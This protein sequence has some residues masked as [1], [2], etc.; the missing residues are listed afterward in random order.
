MA[1]FKWQEF[2]RSAA[3][4]LFQKQCIEGLTTL[5]TSTR[6]LSFMNFLMF[7]K[8]WVADKIFAT[9]TKFEILDPWEPMLCAEPYRQEAHTAHTHI[10]LG[11]YMEL[12][13]IKLQFNINKIYFPKYS[14]SIVFSISVK[15]G[16]HNSLAISKILGNIYSI[17]IW[18]LDAGMYFSEVCV[19]I[20]QNSRVTSQ[21][22]KVMTSKSHFHFSFLLYKRSLWKQVFWYGLCLIRGL[23]GILDCARHHFFL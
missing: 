5:L 2:F 10:L 21:F 20:K 23:E 22:V 11:K 17:H 4:L 18:G 8:I 9:I 13:K 6:S 16:W 19:D 12:Y 7:S 15:T 3:L 1:I 14:D